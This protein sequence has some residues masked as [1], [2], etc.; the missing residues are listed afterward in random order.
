MDDCFR[1]FFW[2]AMIEKPPLRVT[3]S[4]HAGEHR[5]VKARKQ[6]SQGGVGRIVEQMPDFEKLGLFYLGK[7]YDLK[8]RKVT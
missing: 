4:Q 7:T 5:M 8:H 2:D 3:A 1:R 6:Q